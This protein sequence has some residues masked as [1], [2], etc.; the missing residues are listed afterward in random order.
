M[1]KKK[2]FILF[3]VL[4]VISMMGT[5]NCLTV[6]LDNLYNYRKLEADLSYNADVAELLKVDNQTGHIA[7][8]TAKVADV[9]LRTIYTIDAETQAAVD[10]LMGNIK[11]NAIID[12]GVFKINV[13]SKK[14]NADYWTWKT[15]TY[16]LSSVQ[17][18]FAIVVPEK[19]K[20]FD[21]NTLTGNINVSNIN[22]TLKAN[23][24]TGNINI[25]DANIVGDSVIDVKTG[26][27]TTEA[28]INQADKLSLATM[29]GSVK[30]CIPG[31]TG[32]SINASLMTGNI[33]GNFGG[34][35]VG[36]KD[37]TGMSTVS[38]VYNNGG[39]DVTLKTMTGD[40]TVN[41]LE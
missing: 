31:D 19:F 34:M 5:V 39:T 20:A 37:I 36:E 9:R 4:A 15:N 33:N 13:L 32:V 27:I 40:I 23:T 16:P 28:V 21:L 24:Y 3:I 14:D 2:I 1:A 11:I 10:E 18:D 25:I 38:K 35:L 26:D 41:E 17:I 30:L 22:G 29:T 8:R 12:G 6:D 7:L